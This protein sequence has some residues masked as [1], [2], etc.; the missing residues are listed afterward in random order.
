[1]RIKC[2][3]QSQGQG[4]FSV[5]IIIFT[6]MIV[7]VV[8]FISSHVCGSI[9]YRG[10]RWSQ[11]RESSR[12]D[13]YPP[14][15]GALRNQ[16]LATRERSQRALARHGDMSSPH[17]APSSVSQPPGIRATCADAGQCWMLGR[18]EEDSL[19]LRGRIRWFTEL[20]VRC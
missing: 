3:E 11:E 12:Y 19:R 4:G 18:A 15:L 5:H 17:Q 16:I 10:S 8:V 6:V 20:T 14:I 13:L 2:L 9:S 7:R 1:M